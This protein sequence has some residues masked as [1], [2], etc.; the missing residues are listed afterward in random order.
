[1]RRRLDP[2]TLETHAQAIFRKLGLDVSEDY[3]RRVLA[4]IAYLGRE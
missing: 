3:N 4:V 2:K 1:M